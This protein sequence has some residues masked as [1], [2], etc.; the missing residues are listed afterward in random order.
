MY[1]R[2]ACVHAQDAAQSAP[3]YAFQRGALYLGQNIRIYRSADAS[4]LCA[5]YSE[6]ARTEHTSRSTHV[7]RTYAVV[8]AALES[9]GVNRG[10]I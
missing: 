10:V 7:H 9:V 8:R 3:R 4:S 1:S 2:L 6:G 5:V